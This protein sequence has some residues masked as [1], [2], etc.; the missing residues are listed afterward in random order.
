MPLGVV[1]STL[2][3]DAGVGGRRTRREAGDLEGGVHSPFPFKQAL[4]T[5]RGAV[6]IGE[7]GDT[8]RYP[9]AGG[10]SWSWL[11]SH[12]GDQEDTD[13]GEKTAKHKE[14]VVVLS[15]LIEFT[16]QDQA[17][18]DGAEG[19]EYVVDRND[20]GGAEGDHGEVEV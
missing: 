16:E 8:M 17:N 7:G 9:T 6:G 2:P 5:N 1:A 18:K 3:L 14:N 12:G 4:R 20:L 11:F 10:G 15:P 13:K 19:E